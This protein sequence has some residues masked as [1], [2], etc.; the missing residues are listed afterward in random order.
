MFVQNKTVTGSWMM[1][2]Y[3]LYQHQYAGLAT[4]TVQANPVPHRRLNDEQDLAYRAVAAIH[5]ENPETIGSYLERLAFRVRFYRFYFFAPLYIPFAAFLVS[6]REHKF[7]WVLLTILIFALGANFYPYFFPH[8]IAAVTSL[9][10]LASVV[11]LQKLNAWLPTVRPATPL[12]CL[13]ALQFVFWYC[14][15]AAGNQGFLSSIGRYETW[16]FI[17]YGDPQGRILVN[18]ELARMPGKQLVF[19]RY[20]PGHMFQEWIHNAA[21]IDS[22]QVVWAHDLGTIEDEKLRQYYRDRQA[23]L[24]EPDEDPPKLTRY[25]SNAPVFEQVR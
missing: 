1:L 12:L 6:I 14:V 21:N 24:L 17:D 4:F 20:G 25:A 11:G 23:W 22:A 3:M 13:C 5:G 19:V 9:F 10:I 2:P 7:L 16:D 15:H 8:Y 18:R